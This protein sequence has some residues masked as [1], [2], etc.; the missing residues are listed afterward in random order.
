MCTKCQSFCNGLVQ[1]NI[2][3]Y[4]IENY[5]NQDDAVV[6]QQSGKLDVVTCL[7]QE[8]NQMKEKVVLVSYFTQ[9]Q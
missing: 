4:L 9:V 7:L 2:I 5:P 8:L 6:P 3:Q 1:E